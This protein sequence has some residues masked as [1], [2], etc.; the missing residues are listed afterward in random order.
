MEPDFL[1]PDL[2]V[3]RAGQVSPPRIYLTKLPA[4]PATLQPTIFFTQ[5]I[6]EEPTSTRQTA[7]TPTRQQTITSMARVQRCS[8]QK[9]FMNCKIFF[10]FGRLCYNVAG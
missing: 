8:G 3:R 9:S 7:N 5:L 4:P 2:P 6:R 1:V 10:M